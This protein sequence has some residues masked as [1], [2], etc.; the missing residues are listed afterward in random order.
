MNTYF[1]RLMKRDKD[2]P[3]NRTSVVHLTKVIGMVDLF[4]NGFQFGDVLVMNAEE[5]GIYYFFFHNGTISTKESSCRP[6]VP[7]FL[8]VTDQRFTPYYWIELGLNYIHFSDPIIH[9]LIS[10]IKKE[11][12]DS[13]I[14]RVK[15]RKTK[16][17]FFYQT[18]SVDH[19][20]KY[21][22]NHDPIFKYIAH[23]NH[24]IIIG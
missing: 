22:I 4:K 18:N 2:R 19:L 6:V 9:R 8:M 24:L 17:H 3:K 11:K 16:Y 7:Y 23:S 15:I 14:I 10:T 12:V 20:Q 21:M 5:F 1:L 13:G